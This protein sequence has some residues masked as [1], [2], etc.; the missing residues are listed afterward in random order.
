MSRPIRTMEDFAALVGLSRPTVS[1]Y[2][3][4]P[5]SVRPRT[6]ALIEAAIRTSGFQPNLYAVNLNRKRTNILGIVMPN[7][8]DPFYGAL[9]RR[10]ESLAGDAGYLC[11]SLSS[12]GRPEREQRAVE[13]FRMLNVAGA[14]VAPLGISSHRAILADLGRSIPIVTI[15]S[16]LDDTAAFV[17]TDNRQS[18]DLIVDYLVRSGTPPC[19]FGMPTVNRNALGRLE[20]YRAAMTRLG[21]APLVVPT[22][23]PGTWDFERYA[24]DETMRIL[25]GDGFAS[26]TILCANDRMAFGVLGA[27]H[28]RGIAVGRGFAMRVAG[29]DDQPLSAFTCPPL[30]TVAQN[31]GAIG[32]RAVDLLFLKMAVD[33]GAAEIEPGRDRILLPGDLVLRASA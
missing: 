28:Q 26:T 7:T 6:R 11:F 23:D 4:D 15:D 3:N 33:D 30:T 20:A 14:I 1:K 21:H 32:Q 9:L 13:T 17:G 12:D 24:F 19:Y 18:F 27:L 31:I 29:H 2:F 16:P 25:R 10:I 22:V 5:Q 8:I